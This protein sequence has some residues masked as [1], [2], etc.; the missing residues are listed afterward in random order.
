MSTAC[1]ISPVFIKM[2]SGIIEELGA[3][4][5]LDKK[6]AIFK[7]QI[8]AARIALDTQPGQSICV[9]G[10]CLT[11]VKVERDL[12]EFEVMQETIRCTNLGLLKGGDRVNLERALK[13]DARF[14]GH[15][16][17]GHIDGTGIISKRQS[18]GSDIVL[19]VESTVEQILR[20]IALK[21]SVALDGV[22]LTV[23]D[24]KAGIFSINLIPYTLDNTT[25]GLKKEGD[26]VNIEG[27]ILAKYIDRFL[28]Q[29]RQYPA[30]NITSSFLAEHG[31][32]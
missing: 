13:V 14:D 22:S 10:A 21:G 19:I 3:V 27:D 6:G 2:F 20:Y 32:T 9:N 31:F 8:L 18:R 4:K 29:S 23:S 25:L 26:I 28:S 30:S 15:L 7:L 1:S 12:L 5:S 17:S 11:A 24:L 16:V